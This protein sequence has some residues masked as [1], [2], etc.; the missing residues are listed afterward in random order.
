MRT[1]SLIFLVM[2]LLICANPV[3]A[4]SVYKPGHVER[5]DPLGKKY[6][7]NYDLNRNGPFKV[8]VDISVN[9]RQLVNPSVSGDVNDCVESGRG[10]RITWYCDR[11]IPGFSPGVSDVQVSVIAS[12]HSKYRVASLVGFTLIG[13]ASGFVI[14][15]VR[16]YTRALDQYDLYKNNRNPNAPLWS[17]QSRNDYYTETNSAYKKSQY[18]IA[19]GGVLVVAGI[20]ILLNR[21]IKI[22]NLDAIDCVMLENTDFQ[23]VICSMNGGTSYG[24]M[25][26]YHF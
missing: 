3:S 4:Q 10:K 9:G 1:E 13:A 17:V 2:Y 18:L 23:P 16:D 26:S 5:Y 24:M 25:F 11:D 15:G 19:S 7:V 14:P 20:G 22:K 21:A 6:I 8:K 12:K